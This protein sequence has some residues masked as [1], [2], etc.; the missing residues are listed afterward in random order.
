MR[1]LTA[2]TR[3]QD[4]LTTAQAPQR[5]L[6]GVQDW[7]TAIEAAVAAGQHA[8]AP[9]M[10]IDDAHRLSVS[11]WVRPP[12]VRFLHGDPTHKAWMDLC[13]AIIRTLTTHQTHT[14]E[15]CDIWRVRAEKARSR[16]A[17]N[18]ALRKTAQAALELD[19]TFTAA[20]TGR[21][22]IDREDAIM[23]PVGMAI[24]AAGGVDEVARD[25]HYH[26]AWRLR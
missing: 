1:I 8:G 3:M 20:L 16:A 24:A 7:R 21:T 19:R 23:R 14:A 22:L 25:K 10:H 18:A 12:Q 4:T 11:G 5:Q 26:Q 9:G 2:M 13:K 6:Q 15:R 17:R